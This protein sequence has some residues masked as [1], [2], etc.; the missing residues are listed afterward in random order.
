MSLSNL[1]SGKLDQENYTLKSVNSY[2]T[3][4]THWH[5][6]SAYTHVRT[7]TDT[8]RQTVT[9]RETGI[10]EDIWTDRQTDT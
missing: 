9:D 5:K 1:R 10:Q 7:D 2:S 8:D 6:A 4:Y 3:G